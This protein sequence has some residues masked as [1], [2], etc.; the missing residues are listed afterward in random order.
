MLKAAGVD[1]FSIG[2][3]LSA[4][5]ADHVAHLTRMY[6]K[7]S[8]VVA[9]HVDDLHLVEGLLVGSGWAQE[10][11]DE[12][13]ARLPMPGEDAFLFFG[14]SANQASLR[15]DDLPSEVLSLSASS[16]IPLTSLLAAVAIVRHGWAT[17]EV[18]IDLAESALHSA[19]RRIV[20]EAAL[21][22]GGWRWRFASGR[23]RSVQPLVGALM[24][25]SHILDAQ[26]A[27]RLLGE[28]VDVDPQLLTDT[29]S[30]RLFSA[31]LALVNIETLTA[32]L[33]D[34]LRR[35]AAGIV[36]AANAHAESL[37]LVF[38]QFDDETLDEILGLLRTTEKPFAMLHSQ[39]WAATKR[40][41]RDIRRQAASLLVT[42]GRPEDAV[43][44]LALDVTDISG[45]QNVIQ[46]MQL[47][48][49]DLLLACRY[50]VE[51]KRFRLS[52][53]G[54]R[55][56][57]ESGRLRDDFVST[58]WSHLTDDEQRS[59]L[60]RFSEEQLCARGDETLHRFMVNVVFAEKGAV[61]VTVR[62]DAWWCLLRWYGKTKHAWKGPLALESAVLEQFFVGGVSAFF[63]RFLA[64]LH[65]PELSDHRTLEECISTLLRYSPEGGLPGIA[66]ND[67]FGRLIVGLVKVLADSTLSQSLRCDIVRFFEN[68]VRADRTMLTQVVDILSPF[69][70]GDLQFE[71]STTI[72]RLR[73]D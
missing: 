65:D 63:D 16:P 38:A 9:R 23:R 26:V 49:V 51:H 22:F 60:L 11:D 39:L 57:A 43:P 69:E 34:P 45:V 15:L 12:L 58:I 46:R 35:R 55:E 5:D 28:D 73:G 42:I 19:D 40:N 47:G 32:A 18:Q 68:N 10:L 54:V 8:T 36:L 7:Q 29:N 67:A 52:Q 59:E 27:L 30:D 14:Q 17:D 61:S 24:I 41:D 3:R 62:E 70:R 2:E 64:V 48:S 33:A 6:Q 20:D 53:Y 31:A 1:Q 72:A 66:A 4:L 21:A 37:G 71:V 56:L 25:C 44:L 50:L 13:T